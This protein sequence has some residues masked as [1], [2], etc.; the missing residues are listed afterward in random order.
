MLLCRCEGG[1]ALSSACMCYRLQM[2]GQ[3]SEPTRTGGSP[4]P[5]HNQPATA[6]SKSTAEDLQVGVSVVGSKILGE[7][8]EVECSKQ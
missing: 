6:K 5:S 1:H 8:A 7:C 3:E 4:K 2:A